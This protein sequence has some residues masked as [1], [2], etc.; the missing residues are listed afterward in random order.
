MHKLKR[1]RP[2][3]WWLMVALLPMAVTALVGYLTTVL[4]SIGISFSSSRMFPKAEFVGLL[5]Y[6]KLF[7]NERW[8]MSVNNLLLYGVLAISLCMVLGFLM[9][10]FIDQKI[11]AESLFRSIFLYPYAMSFVVTGL[12]W[13]WM[14]NPTMGL[15]S[16]LRGMGFADVT[17]DWIVSQDKV[18]YCIIIAAVWQASG[19]VMAILLA[20]LRGVDAEIW[21]ASRLDGIPTWRV[22]VS[23]VLPMIRGAVATA[24]ILQSIAAIKVYDTV[25]SMT[26]GGPGL[27]S[28]VPAKFI[29]DHLFQRGAIGLASAASVVMLATVLALLVPYYFV[30]KHQAQGGRA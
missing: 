24:F 13:Q 3:N 19:L 2:P 26:G 11:R 18:M 8:L 25:N 14:L 23:I 27:A 12:V 28:E 30:R 9:A 15:Q 20:G 29:L 16:A 5:Q 1:G 17:V 10:V 6:Q 22:Y 21:K 4:W 7:A